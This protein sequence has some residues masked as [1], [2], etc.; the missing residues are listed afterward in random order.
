VMPWYPVEN[1]LVCRCCGVWVEA[2]RRCSWCTGNPVSGSWRGSVA[3]FR[4]RALKSLPDSRFE[5]GPLPEPERV[6]EGRPKRGP[7]QCGKASGYKAHR[8]LGEEPCDEC[9]AAHAE[10]AREASRRLRERRAREKAA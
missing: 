8:R 10:A 1:A 3:E 7:A 4:M 5:H 6:R 2:D 9:K